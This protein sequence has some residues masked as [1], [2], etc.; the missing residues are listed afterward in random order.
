MNLK[1]LKFLMYNKN[2]IILAGGL[3]T[4]IRPISLKTPK[5]LIELNGKPFAYYLFKKLEKYNF[6]KI[7]ICVN[8]LRNEIFEFF[9]VNN[10]ELDIYFV[11]DLDDSP[12]TIG[13]TLNAQKKFNLVNSFIMYGDTYLTID[14]KKIFKKNKANSNSTLFINKNFNKYDKSNIYH[15]LNKNNFIYDSELKNNINYEYIDY[16]L[17]YI[18][19]EQLSEVMKIKKI[20]DLKYFFD[21]SSKKYNLDFEETDDLF[22]EI[23]SF[24]GILRFQND[25]P[26]EKFL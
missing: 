23:G 15:D 25:K 9:K 8:H 17:S 19:Q 12:G 14:F 6:D 21:F 4:R 2:L 26:Y 11:C 16:G 1:V 22:Y 5:I 20:N 3:A 7:I 13:A 24:N 18:F 10:F